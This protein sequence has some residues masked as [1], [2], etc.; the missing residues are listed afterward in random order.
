MSKRLAIG[1][2]ISSIKGVPVV[3]RIVF[4]RIELILFFA[5]FLDPRSGELILGKH[6]FLLLFFLECK[7]LEGATILLNLLFFVQNFFILFGHDEVESF[8]LFYYSIYPKV[9]PGILV[10]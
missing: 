5:F 1:S 10:A 3:Y 4:D 8:Y 2:H 6:S 7:F 9:K